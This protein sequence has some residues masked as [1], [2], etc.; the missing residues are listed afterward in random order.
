[1]TVEYGE[2]KGVNYVADT[3]ELLVRVIG[4]DVKEFHMVR[5]NRHVLHNH[6][7]G[8]HVIGVN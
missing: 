8:E 2:V 1:V 7:V 6:T 3:E 4:G 5:Q